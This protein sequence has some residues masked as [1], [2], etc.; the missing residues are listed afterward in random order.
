MKGKKG[1]PESV[2]TEIGTAWIKLRDN[3]GRLVNRTVDLPVYVT[4]ADKSLPD[5]YTTKSPPEGTWVDSGKSL[6]TVELVLNSTVHLTGKL[7][8]S[9][10]SNPYESR[11][12]SALPG[13]LPTELIQHMPLVINGLLSLISSDKTIPKQEYRPIQGPNGEVKPQNVQSIDLI[14]SDRYADLAFSTLVS[15]VSILSKNKQSHNLENF[16]QNRLDQPQMPDLH[17]S[18]LSVIVTLLGA[19]LKAF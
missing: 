8:H 16:I 12:I 13:E 18:M 4:T 9:F 3:D 7:L 15:I 10:L 14:K 2:L 19:V 11:H 1:E 17:E 5:R 6:L